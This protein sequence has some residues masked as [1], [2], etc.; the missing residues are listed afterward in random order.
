MSKGRRTSLQVQSCTRDNQA[1]LLI[2]LILCRLTRLT[3]LPYLS[4]T[5]PKFICNLESISFALPIPWWAI[6]YLLTKPLKEILSAAASRTEHDTIPPGADV[7]VL[8]GFDLGRLLRRRRIDTSE[9]GAHMMVLALYQTTD[10]K[11]TPFI[12]IEVE[13]SHDDSGSFPD[14]CLAEAQWPPRLSGDNV[15]STCTLFAVQQDDGW[16]LHLRP[17]GQEICDKNCHWPSEYPLLYYESPN[18]YKY[19]EDRSRVCLFLQRIARDDSF[20]PKYTPGWRSAVRISGS[21]AKPYSRRGLKQPWDLGYHRG[22]QE[23]RKYLEVGFQTQMWS[24]KRRLGLRYF[25]FMYDFARDCLPK[26]RKVKPVPED[27]T[28]ENAAE[29]GR[30]SPTASRV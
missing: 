30:I 14:F 24:G 11:I 3:T 5:F 10:G 6:H 15:H 23:A 1:R 29:M 26:R 22:I 21:D 4:L 8:R 19:L 9:D 13:Y 2:A 20:D 27:E 7:Y 16:R 17:K 28:N 18:T 25:Y 12:L